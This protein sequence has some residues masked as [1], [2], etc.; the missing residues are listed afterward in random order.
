MCVCKYWNYMNLCFSMVLFSNWHTFQ[1]LV[2]AADMCMYAEEK[3][4]F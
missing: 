3:P 4:G 1:Q 2:C